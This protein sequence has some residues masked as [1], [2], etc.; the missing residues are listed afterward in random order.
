MIS[1]HERDLTSLDRV[2]QQQDLRHSGDSAW[3]TYCRMPKSFPLVIWCSAT[4]A[5]SMKR[6]CSLRIARPRSCRATSSNLR[7]AE[8]VQ[9]SRLRS[10]LLTCK[11]MIVAHTQLPAL[12]VPVPSEPL[13]SID[14]P[15]STR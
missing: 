1:D 11:W 5:P 3:Q 12:G 13:A 4:W 7:R 15:L 6:W 9:S 10:L 14:A 2:A 8:C